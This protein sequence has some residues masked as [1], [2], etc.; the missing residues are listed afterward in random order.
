M[1]L[2]D[3]RDAD[4]RR[5][6]EALV[7]HEVEFIAVGGVAALAH[8]VQRITRDFDLLIEPS[9]EN[10]RRAIEALVSVGA[11]EFL[12]STKRWTPVESQ[13][14]PAWLLKQPRFFDSD[15][16][17][18]DICNAMEG[19]PHWDTAERG[20]IRVTAFGLEFRVL[21]KD[22]LIRTKLIANREKDQ[23]DVAELTSLDS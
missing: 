16:G 6:V 22:T 18:I 13:A 2:S 21:D 3:R 9:V 12:P 20:S 1:G 7:D 5:V 10:C 4:P 11:G 15:V 8:G 17:A 14:D 23:Q 19:M